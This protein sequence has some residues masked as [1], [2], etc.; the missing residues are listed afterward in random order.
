MQTTT[1]EQHM[2]Y[3]HA[4]LAVAFG[5]CVALA[6]PPALKLTPSVAKPA[7]GDLVRITADVATPAKVKWL[8]VG[9]WQYAADGNGRSILVVCKPGRADVIAVAADDKGEMSDFVVLTFNALDPVPVPVPP[10]GP[11]PIVVPVTPSKLYV[12][13][14]EETDEAAATR[15]A[16]FADPELG[17]RM[18]AKGH[19]WRVVDKDVKGPDRKTPPTDVARFLDAA[20]GKALPQISLV[21]GDGVTR[22]T[23][24][25]GKKTAADLIALLGAWGG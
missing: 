4:T 1:Q 18:K 7:T 14:V 17:A 6:A 23:G 25:W 11:A 22:Y 13:I 2:R 15:G 3:L 20:K 19:A 8:V 21:D 16:M 9:D 24:D 5:A 10:P 12:V